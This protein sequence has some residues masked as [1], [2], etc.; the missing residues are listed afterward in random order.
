[1]LSAAMSSEATFHIIA[2]TVIEVQIN[3]VTVDIPLLSPLLF[4]T[5]V[6]STLAFLYHKQGYLLEHHHL[7]WNKFR[8]PQ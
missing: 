6:T 2:D 5:L 7:H 1:M 3:H 4:A 8:L